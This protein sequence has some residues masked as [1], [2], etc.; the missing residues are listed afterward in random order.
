MVETIFDDNPEYICVWMIAEPTEKDK[1]FIDFKGSN[2]AGKL[3]PGY[4]RDKPFNSSK[5]VTPTSEGDLTRVNYYLIPKQNLKI[6][7]LPP[8]KDNLI[9]GSPDSLLL[10]SVTVSIMKNNKFQGIIGIDLTLDY[11]KDV[12]SK[13]KPYENGF[14]FIT[15]QDNKIIGYHLENLNLTD[16]SSYLSNWSESDYI[17][18]QYPF[19]ITGNEEWKFYVVVLK[20]K[21]FAEL[22]KIRF[23]FII[24]STIIVLEISYIV[25]FTIGRI[26]TKPINNWK[27]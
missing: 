21:V 9:E 7:L 19:T 2:E 3:I 23:I 27:S 16:V 18:K 12:L 15:S 20:S 13:I 25:S 5:E 22:N 10:T 24:V 17:V 6:N 14:V 1:E 26:V 11:I 4:F 8:Y